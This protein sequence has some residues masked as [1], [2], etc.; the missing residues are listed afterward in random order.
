[1]SQEWRDRRQQ[2]LDSESIH[3][4]TV[5]LLQ[6]ERERVAALAGERDCSEEEALR[7]IF[8]SG[9]AYLSGRE[10]LERVQRADTPEKV[11]QELQQTTRQMMAEASHAAALKFQAY[12]LAEDNKVLEMH[13]SAMKN[14]ILMQQ[15][16]MRIYRDDED[17]LR[18]RIRELEVELQRL[19]ADRGEPG[20]TRRGDARTRRGFLK[21]PW[22]SRQDEARVG[23]G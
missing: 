7:L 2:L 16:R 4:L 11:L 8:V 9:L 1:M 20:A 21:L 13:E 12:R 18:G 17:R 19:K 5:P 6:S 15:N 10:V 22:W 14:T 3:L 23:R